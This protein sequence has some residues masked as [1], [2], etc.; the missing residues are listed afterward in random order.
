MTYATKN[1]LPSILLAKDDD[2]HMLDNSLLPPTH[3]PP[4]PIDLLSVTCLCKSIKGRYY[5]ERVSR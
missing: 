2:M 5:R 1:V 4:P 3:A